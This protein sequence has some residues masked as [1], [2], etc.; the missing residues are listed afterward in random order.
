MIDE[1]PVRKKAPENLRLHCSKHD[2]A[3]VAELFYY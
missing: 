1:L 2:P 3:N